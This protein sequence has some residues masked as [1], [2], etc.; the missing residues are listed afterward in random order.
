[1][2]HLQ[3]RDTKGGSN[4]FSEKSLFKHSF[5]LL[6]DL[7]VSELLVDGSFVCSF[8][9]RNVIGEKLQFSLGS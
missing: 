6:N 1:M 3:G 8:V 7:K 4:Q 5:K 9:L 2:F